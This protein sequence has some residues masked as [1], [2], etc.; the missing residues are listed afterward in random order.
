MHQKT[1]VLER[2][3][4]MAS[5]EKRGDGYRITVSNGRDINGK[6]VLEKTTWK[7]DPG[8]TTRQNEKDLE[9]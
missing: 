2:M 4:F 7:P 6:Q 8:K 3:F 9:A 5:I 1:G